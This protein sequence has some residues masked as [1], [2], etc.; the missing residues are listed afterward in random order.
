MQS[1]EC[2]EKFWYEDWQM[3]VENK[4]GSV[5]DDQQKYEEP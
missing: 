4:E 3:A 5:Q 2:V 1:S